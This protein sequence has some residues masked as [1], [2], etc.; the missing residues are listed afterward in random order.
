MNLWKDYLPEFEGYVLEAK[1]A[2]IGG[3][4]FTDSQ[5]DAFAVAERIA[6]RFSLA[7]RVLISTPMWNFGIPYKLKHLIDLVS[8]KDVLFTFDERGLNGMLREKKAAVIYA[9][10]LDYNAAGSTP[11]ADYDFQKPYIELWLRFIGIGDIAA[12]IV[13]K[14]LFGPEIDVEARQAAKAQAEESQ[15]TTFIRACSPTRCWCRPRAAPR[16]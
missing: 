14:T 5:R 11:A 13:E 2:R 1:Y 10:G 6:V 8:Q 9:R 15:R 3:R 4:P 12:I 16:R 7:D